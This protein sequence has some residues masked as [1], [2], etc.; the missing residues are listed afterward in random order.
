MFTRV[1]IKTRQSLLLIA[2]EFLT[3][4]KIPVNNPKRIVENRV[5]LIL[6]SYKILNNLNYSYKSEYDKYLNTLNSEINNI[7]FEGF[8]INGK[9]QKITVPEFYIKQDG[10]C[11]YLYAKGVLKK[12]S[13]N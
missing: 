11:I 10:I 2:T 6:I 5:F 8:T 4:R 1:L 3:N 12:V 7:K 13:I 9:I